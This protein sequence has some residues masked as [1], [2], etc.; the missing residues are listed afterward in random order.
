MQCGS[1]GALLEMR[2]RLLE[3]WQ[4]VHTSTSD[5]SGESAKRSGSVREGAR[6]CADAWPNHPLTTTAFS[7]V[8]RHFLFSRH[9]V[10][11]PRE[12]G[13]I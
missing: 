8:K 5:Q 6:Q 3:A 1:S 4:P 11:F 10:V 13:G 2:H 9:H 12:V 7:R